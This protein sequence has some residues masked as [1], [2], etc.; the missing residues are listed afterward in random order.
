MAGGVGGAGSI[1]VPTRFAQFLS[2]DPQ[3]EARHSE[4]VEYDVDGPQD[5]ASNPEESVS[6]LICSSSEK[7]NIC[8]N[9]EYS[10]ARRP[11]DEYERQN[12]KLTKRGKANSCD[13]YVGSQSYGE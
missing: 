9:R 12:S 4:R 11:S 6:R 1:P 10:N 5:C 13:N 3:N 2:G 7:E 8:E